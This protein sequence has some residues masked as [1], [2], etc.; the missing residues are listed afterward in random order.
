MR[1]QCNCG[2]G[3]ATESLDMEI[4]VWGKP[5]M[6]TIEVCQKCKDAWE[7]ETRATTPYTREYHLRH[8]NQVASSIR[9]VVAEWFEDGGDDYA[10]TKR[11][12]NEM[13]LWSRSLSAELAAVADIDY[14]EHVRRDV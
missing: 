1:A 2:Y 8:I 14:K 10:Q 9:S 4:S 3:I 5:E 11:L 6:R 13:L 7:Q 12:A